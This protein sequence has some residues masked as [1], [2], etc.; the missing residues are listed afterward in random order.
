VPEQPP[1]ATS[2]DFA[3]AEATPAETPAAEEPAK[4]RKRRAK[5]G[6]AEPA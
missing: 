6:G 4:P 2:A 1:P 5:A 3:P